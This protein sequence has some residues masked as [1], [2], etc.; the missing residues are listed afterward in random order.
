[1][2]VPWYCHHPPVT[3]TRDG[4][5]VLPPPGAAHARVVGVTHN[6]SANKKT[7]CACWYG[8]CGERRG[9]KLPA[10][11]CTEL[12]K[13]RCL[14]LP[15]LLCDGTSML[16]PLPP[17]PL[18]CCRCQAASTTCHSGGQAQQAAG[19]QTT[20]PRWWH[21]PSCNLQSFYLEPTA[22]PWSTR[23]KPLRR[24]HPLPGSKD[25]VG[26]DQ[27]PLAALRRL[28]GPRLLRQLHHV[29]LVLLLRGEGAVAAAAGTGQGPP[30]SAA[31]VAAIGSGGGGC[32]RRPG[33]AVAS[34]GVLLELDDPGS[35][36]G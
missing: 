3:T 16:L 35:K 7:L 34:A 9:E 29:L 32:W 14:L 22:K 20:D 21:R 8:T 26:D 28:G 12:L 31:A 6:K 10:P 13:S 30:G 27:R 4:T 36:E 24:S 23:V 33:G 15:P 19:V 5:T 1:M 17:L 25:L 11:A 18:P 2:V